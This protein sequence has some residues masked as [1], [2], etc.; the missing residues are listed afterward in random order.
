MTESY[1]KAIDDLLL[2]LQKRSEEVAD[3]KR[4]INQLCKLAG[5]PLRFDDVSVESVQGRAIRPDQFFGKAQATA[6]KEYLKMKGSAATI[7]EI[8]DALLRGGYSFTGT[9][10]LWKRGLSIALS[11]NSKGFVYIKNNKSYG[12]PE[13]YPDLHLWDTK[14]NGKAEEES[15]SELPESEEQDNSKDKN[16]TPKQE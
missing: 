8:Y 4:T 2:D 13:F 10:K 15:E 1:K 6:V 12:L 14:E 3:I 11:K 9:E 16:K 5:E 7:D